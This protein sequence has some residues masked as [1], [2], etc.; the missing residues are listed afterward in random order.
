MSGAG[1]NKN[2]DITEERFRETALSH[3]DGLYAYAMTL[4]RN[5]AEAEE[6]VRETYIRAMKAFERLRP[7]TNV[8]SWLFTILRNI[9]VNQVRS[10][11]GKRPEFKDE[12]SKDLPSSWL[13]RVKTA[14]VHTAIEKLP[15]AY[16]EVIVLREFEE[17][18]YEDIAQILNCPPGT[19]VSRLSRARDKLRDALRQWNLTAFEAANA[20]GE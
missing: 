3:L 9:R 6:L 19:V 11:R 13:S 10:R 4:T 14:D 20:T 16:R 15:E 17:L 12:S 7:D 8:K 2:S 18:S 5:R 1:T